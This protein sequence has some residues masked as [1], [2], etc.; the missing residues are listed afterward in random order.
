M[1]KICHS[2]YIT[3]EPEIVSLQI[4]SE[5]DFVI[6]ASDG[7][8]EVLSNEEAVQVVARKLKMMAKTMYFSCL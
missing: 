6:L 4:E 5:N 7:L 2:R 8:W 1:A 3:C